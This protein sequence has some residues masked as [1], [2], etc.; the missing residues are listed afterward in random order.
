MNVVFQF[1]A[2]CSADYNQA[3]P[4]L[5]Y[6]SNNSLVDI[7]LDHVTTQY[8]ESRFALNLVYVSNK[9]INE[10]MSVVT[11]RSIDDEHSPGSFLVSSNF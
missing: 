4:N 10:S 7:V 5:Q 1:Q 2:F 6:N 3:L 9:H 8:K 11:E